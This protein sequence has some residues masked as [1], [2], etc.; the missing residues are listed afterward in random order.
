MIELIHKRRSE[1]DDCHALDVFM[2]A[3]R[4]QRVQ[5]HIAREL[6][7][8]LAKAKEERTGMFLSIETC[9]YLDLCY[10]A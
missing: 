4:K 2:E 7:R 3:L 5:A 8:A 1:K 10:S 6:Q 9:L